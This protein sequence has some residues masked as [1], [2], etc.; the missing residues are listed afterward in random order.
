[1]SMFKYAPI[2][3]LFCNKTTYEEITK[4]HKRALR[5]LLCDFRS[6][7]EVLLQ[8]A[9]CKTVHEIHLFFLLCEVF[10]SENN[11]NPKFMQQIFLTKKIKFNLRNKVLMSLPT[12]N[13]QRFGTQSFVF[14]GSLLWNQIPESSKVEKSID[15]FKSSLEK[16][17]L[18]N[19]CLCKI[20]T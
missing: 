10:K 4:V 1:M 8:N 17:N 2:I 18:S 16:I 3:W 6:S 5:S 11:L 20:C 15:S 9:K 13:S 12:A 7:Y 19:I 14:R